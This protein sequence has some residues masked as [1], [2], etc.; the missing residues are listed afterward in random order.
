M[1]D[2]M[3]QVDQGGQQPVD[4]HQ[5]MPGAGPDR[6]LTWPIG[7]ACLPARLPSRP[8][9]DD[10]LSEDLR[11]QSG[12]PAFSDSGGTGQAPRHPTTL[13]RPSRASRPAH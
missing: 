10:Q 5:P 2:S 7:Q 11:E 3:A 9:L 12:H 6:P 1:G 13:L 4:E 8:E